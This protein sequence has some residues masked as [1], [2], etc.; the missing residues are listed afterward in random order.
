MTLKLLS[1]TYRIA[2]FSNVR[3]INRADTI[4]EIQT[5][6][7]A[8]KK[9]KVIYQYKNIYG[10]IKWFVDD[11]KFIQFQT[12]DG[13]YSIVVIMACPKWVCMDVYV[14]QHIETFIRKTGNSFI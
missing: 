10:V 14:T 5:S 2:I 8:L 11:K 13:S 4:I 12:A 3:Q 6:L 1:P 7:H 9:I